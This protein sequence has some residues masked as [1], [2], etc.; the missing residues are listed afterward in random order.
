MEVTGYLERLDDAYLD[1]SC[2]A[3]PLRRGA[4]V[5]FKAVEAVAAGFP[6][7]TTTVGAE[8]V[9]DA[10][11]TPPDRVHDDPASFARALA[12]VLLDP[13]PALAQRPGRP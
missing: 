10:T 13:E 6:L 5:K 2:V 4:G 3:V 1:V 11:G 9:G 8:G 12:D 7:V